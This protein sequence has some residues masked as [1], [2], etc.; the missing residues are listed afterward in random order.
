M[1]AKEMFEKVGYVQSFDDKGTIFYE[2]TRGRNFLFL[3]SGEVVGCK[4]VNKYELK[5]ILQQC[6][7][8]GWLDD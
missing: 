1:T 4:T 6:K 5:A 7:E 3:K 2:N 8:L